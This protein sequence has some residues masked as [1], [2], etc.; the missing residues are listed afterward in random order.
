MDKNDIQYFCV[1]HRWTYNLLLEIV[2]ESLAFVYITK[3]WFVLYVM[4]VHM[5]P[6]AIPC[7]IFFNISHMWRAC[8]MCTSRPYS[9]I[10]LQ[11]PQHNGSHNGSY[12]KWYNKNSVCLVRYHQG[13]WPMHWQLSF[14][15]GLLS[16]TQSFGLRMCRE[17]GKGIPGRRLQGNR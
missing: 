11:I 7:L 8:F 9:G 5:H 17:C 2:I 15:M 16:D 10:K 14:C 4:C 1:M 13:T 6:C 12:L 3:Q